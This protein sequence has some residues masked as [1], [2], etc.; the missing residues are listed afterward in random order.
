MEHF[1]TDRERLLEKA[2]D[3]LEFARGDLELAGETDL[4]QLVHVIQARTEELVT[5]RVVPAP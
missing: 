2:V 4:A 3:A 5:C 1:M